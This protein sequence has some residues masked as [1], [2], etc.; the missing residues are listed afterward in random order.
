MSL[1][2]LLSSFFLLAGFAEEPGEVAVDEQGH[3]IEDDHDDDGD[4]DLPQYGLVKGTGADQLGDQELDDADEVVLQGKIGDA[5][6]GDCASDT[7]GA[8]TVLQPLARGNVAG[9][10]QDDGFR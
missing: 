4:G 3:R 10:H 8:A 9:D 2:C 6:D 7:T 5:G 1:L